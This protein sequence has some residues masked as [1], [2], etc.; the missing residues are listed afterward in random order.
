MRILRLVTFA[1]AISLAGCEFVTY[2][3]PGPHSYEEVVV[4]SS[5]DPVVTVVYDP[6]EVCYEEPPF[7]REAVWCEHYTY[8]TC[9]GWE[10][11]YGPLCDEVWCYWDSMCG[12]EY[13]DFIC[14]EPYPYY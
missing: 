9:C 13:D 6:Y 5:P 4:V 7:Y 1:A 12:W 14:Y 3:H 8:G 11:S 2:E 10:V